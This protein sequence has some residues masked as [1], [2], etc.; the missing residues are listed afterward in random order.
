[1]GAVARGVKKVKKAKKVKRS[2]Q[3][4]AAGTELGAAYRSGWK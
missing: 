3:G 4:W 2:Q 1:M